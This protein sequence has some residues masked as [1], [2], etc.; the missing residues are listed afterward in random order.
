VDICLCLSLAHLDPY[1]YIISFSSLD[2]ISNLDIISFSSLDIIS[3]L[4]II[5]FSSHSK[6][7]CVAFGCRLWDAYSA[8]KT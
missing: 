6:C 3:D 1:I 8:S 4:D 2:I 5:S 7:K